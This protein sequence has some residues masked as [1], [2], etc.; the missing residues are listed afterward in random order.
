MIRPLTPDEIAARIE[1]VRN[2]LS[3][4]SERLDGLTIL[5]ERLNLMVELTMAEVIASSAAGSVDKR[6]AEALAA[7]AMTAEPGAEDRRDILTR[8]REA[9]AEAK[10]LREAQHTRRAILDGLRA[11]AFAI[12]AELRS[13]SFG[14][15]A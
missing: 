10:A 13:L 8:A 7:C 14:R 9:A 3:R 6:K 4:E 12:A 11:Q 2:E 15:S 1:D 5:S